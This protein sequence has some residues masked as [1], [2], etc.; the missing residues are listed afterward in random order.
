MKKRILAL[1]LGGCMA[2]A[3]IS[4]NV[5]TVVQA[6]EE[7][8]TDCSW[9][10]EAHVTSGSVAVNDDGQLTMTVSVTGL[11]TD[12]GG[13]VQIYPLEKYVGDGKNLTE[14]KETDYLIAVLDEWMITED[15]SQPYPLQIKQNGTY[16]LPDLTGGKTYYVYAMVY[17]W[18]GM[19]HGSD[20]GQH[21]PLYLGSGT[22]T[23]GSGSAS[24]HTPSAGDTSS[25]NSSSDSSSEDSSSA[26][27]AD[28]YVVYENNLMS[29]IDEVQSGTTIALNKGVTTLS[30]AVMKELLERGDVSLKLEFS[31]EGKY[32]VII[33]PAGAALD[34]DIPWYGPL[35]L[36]QH[37]GNSAED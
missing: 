14:E 7:G 2:V 1:L 32:Y 20:S 8:E 36:A 9:K 4:L 15:H 18:H 19:A 5:P 11:V 3:G 28:P 16:V 35:Y 30:N 21:L 12:D 29:Q 31:Y 33:I 37:F 27:A 17:E 6:E 34:N 24:V 25:D 23:A 22:P 10:S 26:S 13:H